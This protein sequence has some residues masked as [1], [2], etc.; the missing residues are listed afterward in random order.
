[1]DDNKD[2]SKDD[3]VSV[4]LDPEIEKNT[5]DVCRY[6]LEDKMLDDN[7]LLKPCACTNPVCK[8]CLK[9]RIGVYKFTKCEICLEDFKLGPDA[10]MVIVLKPIENSID[11][12]NDSPYY[13]NIDNSIR[14]WCSA[15]SCLFLLVIIVL[16]LKIS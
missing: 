12:I 2:D 14:L 15:A 16:M 7:I 9:K 8:D 3:F 10:G 6:C 4:S 11:E 1:M 13:C 5:V